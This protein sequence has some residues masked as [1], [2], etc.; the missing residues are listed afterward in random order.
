MKYLFSLFSLIS[1]LNRQ[2]VRL[3]KD[4]LMLSLNR[5]VMAP[6]GTVEWTDLSKSLPPTT[7][8]VISAD[9]LHSELLGQR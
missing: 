7:V 2:S 5:S 3:H 9:P 6:R 4:F 8:P 1:K